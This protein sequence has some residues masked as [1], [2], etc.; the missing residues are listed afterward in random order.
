VPLL[1]LLAAVIAGLGG[2]PS[3]GAPGAQT[4]TCAAV[5]VSCGLSLMVLK[6]IDWDGV[7]GLRGTGVHLAHQ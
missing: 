5:A 1:P 6:Q 4:L 7:A 3:S 2:A